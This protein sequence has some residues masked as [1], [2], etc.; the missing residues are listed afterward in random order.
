MALVPLRFS[1]A[2]WAVLA[3]DALCESRTKYAAATLLM[4]ALTTL[5][6][7]SMAAAG[8]SLPPELAAALLW[9]V[10]FFCAMAGLARVYSGARCCSICC[11]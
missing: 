2:V 8:V 7:V 4:F 6:S 3:K 10:L 5:A 1:R 11:C 9:I